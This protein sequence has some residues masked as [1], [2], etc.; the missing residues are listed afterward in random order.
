M[1]IVP[2]VPVADPCPQGPTRQ[3]C[4]NEHHVENPPTV[5]RNSWP[6]FARQ[7][8]GF[9]STL[10]MRLLPSQER[11]YVP[12]LAEGSPDW[13]HGKSGII[14]KWIGHASWL[15]EVVDV[16]LISHNHYDH[17]DVATVRFLRERGNGR[18]RLLRALGVKS[19]LLGMGVGDEHVTELDWWQG[20]EVNVGEARTRLVCTPSQHFS[21]R[22]ICDAGCGLWD[23]GYRSVPQDTV[24]V[25]DLPRC[26]A[27]KDIGELYGPFNLALLPISCFLPRTM[28][29]R[30][31]G[32]HHGTVRGMVSGAFE[33]VRDPPQLW[34]EAAEKAV[35]TWGGEISICGVGETVVV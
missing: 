33:D 19:S 13:G 7:S 18:V 3:G 31:V 27:F 30:S 24:N 12:V 22:S 20:V 23:T 11:N 29:K 17:L 2:S 10:R 26:P 14:A 15:V 5:F 21:E 34:K 28:I 32:M 1:T 6:S 25:A 9:A 16:V 35:L 4:L 8:K